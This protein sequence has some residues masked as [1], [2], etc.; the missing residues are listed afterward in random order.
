MP[1]IA[2]EL[3]TERLRLRPL[4][5]ADA[6]AIAEQVNDWDVVRYTTSIPFPYDRAMAEDF[7][8]SQQK[9]WQAWSGS[10]VPDEEV[11]FAI[12]RNSDRRLIGCIG[13]Q[14]AE[15]GPEAAEGGLEFGYWLGRR[16]WGQGYATEAVG[17]LVRFGFLDLNLPEIWGA[18]VPNNDA[19]HRVMEKNGFVIVG[20]GERPSDVRGHPLPV[21]LRKLT[22]AQWAAAQ[23]TTV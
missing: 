6:P 11:A 15:A 16:H 17:R 1:T 19:S 8:A 4:H 9:R 21:I 20:A 10:Q 23:A 2:V 5:P 14:P 18:A 13:L 7:I 22:R 3:T 12:E